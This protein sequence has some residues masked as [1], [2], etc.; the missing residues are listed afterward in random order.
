[1]GPVVAMLESLPDHFLVLNG[2]V[3]TDLDFRIVLHHHTERGADLTIATYRRRVPID[4]G[5]LSV[6][7]GRVISFEEKPILDYLVSM[8]V[9]GLSRETLSGFASG[10]ALGFDELVLN[11]LARDRLIAGFEHEGYWLDIGRPEDYDRAN[12]DFPRLRSAL[13][14]E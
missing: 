10:T 14:G 3:L 7:A 6:E 11:L 12:E 9:Y 2:D 13:L 8:G 5:V 1:M 4:F